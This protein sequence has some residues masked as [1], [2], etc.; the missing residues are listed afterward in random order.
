MTF[1]RVLKKGLMNIHC[2]T[3]RSWKD[4]GKEMME[5]WI[6]MKVHEVKTRKVLG[7]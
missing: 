6:G 7:F 3:Q 5:G 4:W 2:G 1:V